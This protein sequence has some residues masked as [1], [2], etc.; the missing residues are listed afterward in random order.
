LGKKVPKL[1]LGNQGERGALCFRVKTGD[2]RATDP[3]NAENYGK[4]A[5]KPCFLPIFSGFPAL[6]ILN[7]R[8]NG[9]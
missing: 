3:K 1:E 8:K 7:F 2:K 6:S 5:D 9:L 4:I